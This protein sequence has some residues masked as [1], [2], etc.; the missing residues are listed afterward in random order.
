MRRAGELDENKIIDL[1]VEVK[2]DVATL[3]GKLD[4]FN[5]LC[6]K[7]DNL[8]VKL[9]SVKDRSESNTHR[10]NRLEGHNVWIWRTIGGTIIVGFITAFYNLL[11]I[12]Y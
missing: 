4:R 2:T 3:I 9:T 10:I 7:T 12:L 8:E 11:K 5:N 1:L 6:D